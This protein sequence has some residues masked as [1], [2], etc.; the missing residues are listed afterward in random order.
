MDVAQPIRR[1]T[2][3]AKG[4]NTSTEILELALKSRVN[5]VNRPERFVIS[6]ILASSDYQVERCYQDGPLEGF[7]V[8]GKTVL[9]P[10]G[11]THAHSY[12]GGSARAICCYWDP[13]W[14]TNLLGECPAWDT[15][16]LRATIDVA[17]ND[18]QQIL[19]N[20]CLE[21]MNPGFCTDMIIDGLGRALLGQV[22]RYI[23]GKRDEPVDALS[24]VSPASIRRAKDFIDASLHL[25]LTTTMIAHA[26]GLS[27]SH[28]TRQFKAATGFTLHAYLEEMRTIRAKEL[29][30]EDSL[31]IKE[32]SYR[33]GFRSHSSFSTAFVQKTGVT[34]LHYRRRSGRPH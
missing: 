22:A 16:T 34:P 9:S 31:P 4:G 29:L 33:V 21:T 24:T 10:P 26:A 6:S 17:D 25:G 8:L 23:W 19:L 3:R 28:L 7:H 11:I 13:S 2:L 12:S 30:K 14:M 32:I 5:H 20:L 1:V 15:D 27:R 18:I